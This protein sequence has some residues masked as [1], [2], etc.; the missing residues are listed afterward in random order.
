[1]TLKL[2]LYLH[3]AR[4]TARRPTD[5]TSNGET[6]NGGESV[7]LLSSALSSNGNSKLNADSDSDILE[8]IDKCPVLSQDSGSRVKQ[9]RC[10]DLRGVICGFP[11]DELVSVCT[12]RSR[13]YKPEHWVVLSN[14]RSLML[15]S[16]YPIQCHQELQT[17]KPPLLGAVFSN[18]FDRSNI[19]RGKNG[20]L[21]TDSEDE[22]HIHSTSSEIS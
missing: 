21:T 14:H 9:P 11:K 2:T 7:T 15:R 19:Y 6:L 18:R 4:H 13:R 16:Y 17:K 20:S 22:I 8:N 12:T 10:F 1:M 3:A 5:L